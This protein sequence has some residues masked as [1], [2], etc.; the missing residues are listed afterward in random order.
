MYDVLEYLVNHNLVGMTLFTGIVLV[1]FST[2]LLVDYSKRLHSV[3]RRNTKAL[4]EESKRLEEEAI[5]EVVPSMEEE[6]SVEEVEQEPKEISVTLTNSSWKEE[7]KP[8]VEEEPKVAMEEK[9]DLDSPTTT[10][11]PI[12]EIKYV[13]ESLEQTRAQEELVHLT[14]ALE[15]AYQ[16]MEEKKPEIE[17]ASQDPIEKTEFERKQEED[18]IISLDELFAKGM[19]FYEANEEVQ[20]Q[21]EGN[22]PINLQELELRYREKVSDAVEESEEPPTIVLPSFEEIGQTEGTRFQNSPVISPVYGVEAA[23]STIHSLALENTANYDKLDDEIRKTS[24]FIETLK[25]LQRKLD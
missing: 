23:K 11:E 21:D 13:D 22:E 20:Y 7:S 15:D 9:V 19:K 17:E 16:E 2:L 12:K 3:K 10:L 14:K 6:I 18:A 8:I 25:E 1:F 24:E 5:V 4:L